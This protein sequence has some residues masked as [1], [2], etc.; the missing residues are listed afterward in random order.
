MQNPSTFYNINNTKMINRYTFILFFLLSLQLGFAQSVWSGDVN[1]NGVVNKIDLLYLGYAFG[2]TG[3]A[4][5]TINGAW[6]AQTAPE[7]WSG[8]FPNGINF[9]YA[10]CNGDG[11]VD[12][13]DADVLIQNIGLSHDDVL[14][15]PDERPIGELGTNPECRLMNNLPAAPVDQLFTIDIS[16]G[17]QDIP[18]ENMS[19]MTFILDVEPDIIGLNNTTFTLNEN[20]WLESDEEQSLVVQHIDEERA[21]LKVAYTKTD[22]IPLSGFGPLATVSFLIEGDI[23]NFLVRDTI[24]YTI[25]SIVVLMDDLTAIPIVAD[26]LLLPIDE[27]LI[28]SMLEENKLSTIEVYPNP[29]KGFLLI[30]STDVI[31]EKVELINA[32]GQKVF[33]KNLKNT[34]FQSIDFQHLQQGI[35]YVKIFAEQG[36]KTEIVHK[37][38]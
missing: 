31:L 17:D 37:I 27:N 22:R 30:E 13:L 15:V 1:N 9:L 3:N 38:N 2:E 11:V 28:V 36:I 12:E 18:I 21:R 26:T 32:I 35:Y 10:D 16:L 6:E 24:T 4:R 8:S 19:G 20:T 29:N 7:L 34:T 33:S 25:D 5:T 23:V 14:F